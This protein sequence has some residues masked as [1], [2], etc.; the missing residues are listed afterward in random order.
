MTVQAL[1]RLE[2][3]HRSAAILVNEPLSRSSPDSF[4]VGSLSQIVGS[5]GG[6]TRSSNK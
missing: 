4:P 6:E 2:C 1:M 5:I 3:Y